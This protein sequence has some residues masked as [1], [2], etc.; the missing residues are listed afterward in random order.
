LAWTATQTHIF[1]PFFTTKDKGKGTGLGLATVYG[2]VKQSDGYIEV[3]SEI[4]VGTTFK[5]YLPRVDEPVDPERDSPRA[6]PSLHGNE[7][8]LLVEDEDSLR[9]LTQHVLKFLG[10][11]VLEA[12]NGGEGCR[13]SAEHQ[14]KIDLVLTDVIMPE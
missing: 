9:T 10:Y 11:T 14:G 2:V 12:S 8:I 7:T 3:H 4:G 13:V 5:I 1:E 6:T